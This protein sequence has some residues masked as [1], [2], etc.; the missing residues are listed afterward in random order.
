MAGG[1]SVSG[2]LWIGFGARAVTVAAIEGG[3]VL[4]PPMKVETPSF[5]ASALNNP[6][7]VNTNAGIVLFPPVKVEALQLGP[8]LPDSRTG[9]GMVLF[10]PAM[11]TAL[12]E[13][14]GTG[15][16][17]ALFPPMAMDTS[18]SAV[19]GDGSSDAVSSTGNSVGTGDTSTTVTAT[20]T[21]QTTSTSTVSTS[22]G[23]TTSSETTTAT[24]SSANTVYPVGAGVSD[25]ECDGLCWW[26]WAIIGL[27]VVFCMAG[28]AG[29]LAVLL[30]RAFWRIGTTEDKHI[31]FKQANASPKIVPC[32]D[33]N[34][35]HQDNSNGGPGMVPVMVGDAS[36]SG[37]NEDTARRSTD[38]EEGSTHDAEAAAATVMV[39]RPVECEEVT[40]RQQQMQEDKERERERLEKEQ[41]EE[42]EARNRQ[43]QEE[44]QEERHQREMQRQRELAEERAKQQ[45]EQ[46][47]E[48]LHRLEQEA[49]EAKQRAKRIQDEQEQEEARRSQQEAHRK[50]E[51]RMAEE[52][53]ERQRS[54]CRAWAGPWV[55]QMSIR[56]VSA[57]LVDQTCVELP[58]SKYYA[59]HIQ[60]CVG[61]ASWQAFN[62]LPFQE[63]H[64]LRAQVHLKA[65]VDV[66]DQMQLAAAISRARA[67]TLP[68][69]SIWYAEVAMR[70][71]IIVAEVWSLCSSENAGMTWQRTWQ[72]L[73]GRRPA[74][75]RE[76][77]ARARKDPCTVVME[78][79]HLANSG[80]AFSPQ[81]PS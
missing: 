51:Q 61:V 40:E 58:W 46:E 65:A 76:L 45:A 66:G 49:E 44:E 75:L 63:Q 13:T 26:A 5:E 3:M 28:I 15:E 24:S 70:R 19:A 33:C 73:R 71:L 9:K 4:F 23:T 67:W 48:E 7:M 57:K 10:P 79:Q 80:E 55:R 59:T 60:P 37:R 68:T 17:I 41:A 27:L 35:Q 22:T 72:L 50:A 56:I 12:T 29:C 36:I 30:L 1:W 74:V 42:E 53:E 43:K 64:R 78:L 81:P 25:N 69:D 2:R 54:E 16:G 8:I 77:L 62:D 20:A 34:E 18:S 21:T 38:E 6:D 39:V 47:R 14:Q 31:D 32:H 11:V 52:A